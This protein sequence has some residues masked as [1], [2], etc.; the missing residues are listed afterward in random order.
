[1]LK[2]LKWGEGHIFQS[3][4]NG[5]EVFIT[6]I[7]ISKLYIIS[8]WFLIV[9]NIIYYF[10]ISGFKSRFRSKSKKFQ[11][12]GTYLNESAKL[13]YT[14]SLVESKRGMRC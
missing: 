9:I 11:E 1:M 7:S 3:F 8:I 5:N 6:I 4:Q 10:K 12:L 13:K 14:L 2:V